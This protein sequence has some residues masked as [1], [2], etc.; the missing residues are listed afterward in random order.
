MMRDLT[1][2]AAL[3]SELTEEESIALFP[4]DIAAG[5]IGISRSGYGIFAYNIMAHFAMVSG[6]D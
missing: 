2:G 1:P 4:L 3:C 5:I 6:R